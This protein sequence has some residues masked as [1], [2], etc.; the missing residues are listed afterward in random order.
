MRSLILTL[1]L[2]G[3]LQ[4]TGDRYQIQR[5]I[6]PNWMVALMEPV[7][8][9]NTLVTFSTDTTFALF[10]SASDTYDL[11]QGATTMEAVIAYGYI[12]VANATD[13][14][15]TALKV[16]LSSGSI[17]HLQTITGL[18]SIQ[19][20]VF[21]YPSYLYAGYSG[22]VQ[23]YN[24]DYTTG[25]LTASGSATSFGGPVLD[26]AVISNG[27]GLYVNRNG[28]TLYEASIGS[29]GTLTP[30]NSFGH[31]S[32]T[33]MDAATSVSSGNSFLMVSDDGANTLTSY[34]ISNTTGYLTYADSISSTSPVAIGYLNYYD[35]I[36][37][38]SNDGTMR[39]Y[40]HDANGNLTLNFTHTAVSDTPLDGH[41]TSTDES[42]YFSLGLLGVSTWTIGN[43]G[44]GADLLFR[45]TTSLTDY[46][47]YAKKIAFLLRE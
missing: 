16:N 40:V 38:Q 32:I 25:L 11:G 37:V 15:L 20:V 3:C 46:G 33:S 39:M 9:N 12:Y 6:Y 28:N 34:S 30:N 8:G 2:S 23:L 17:T 21:L 4:R 14:T 22:G 1:L 5:Y 47:Q 42:L 31:S 19:S 27:K 13:G 45:R 43:S 26:M 10:E 41:I 7:S 35:S 29:N 36:S 18:T 44:N 24:L